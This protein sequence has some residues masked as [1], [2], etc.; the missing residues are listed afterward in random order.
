M[1]NFLESSRK[2]LR[3]LLKYLNDRILVRLKNGEEYRGRMISCD[4]NMN[5]VLKD[6]GHYKS[7]EPIVQYGS[8]IIRGS[9]INYICVKDAD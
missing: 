6:A 7:D 1:A 3:F 2:P 9:F 8:L 4:I 5:L